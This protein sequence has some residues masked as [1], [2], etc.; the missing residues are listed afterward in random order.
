MLQRVKKMR[1]KVC[2]GCGRGMPK[3]ST[4]CIHCGTDTLFTT[5]K[6]KSFN[7][8]ILS[9]ITCIV[10]FTAWKAIE[11]KEYIENPPVH[12]FDLSYDPDKFLDL[13]NIDSYGDNNWL[14]RFSKK[15][16]GSSYKGISAQTI[17]TNI[18]KTKY[19]GSSKMELN[20]VRN[21]TNEFE[22]LFQLMG[23]FD[24]N[25]SKKSC[26]LRV[27]F[28]GNS[29][30]EFEYKKVPNSKD[31]LIYI[32]DKNKFI[33]K[34]RNAKKITVGVNVYNSGVVNYYFNV[35]NLILDFKTE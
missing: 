2:R 24:C 25:V 14:Y 13:K 23:Q 8:T 5:I 15:S 35:K 17:S 1:L 18:V 30:E 4:K 26:K 11:I 10:S 32:V 9:L 12:Y 27:R 7:V 6:K 34:L 22:A 31:D 33:K 3:D 20:L 16:D 29:F 21:K 28:D 19:Y